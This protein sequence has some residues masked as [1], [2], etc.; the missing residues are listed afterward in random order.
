M[1]ASYSANGKCKQLTNSTDFYTFDDGTTL[2]WNTARWS[3]SE[4]EEGNLY[5]ES[6]R[7]SVLFNKYT[8]S[9][10]QDNAL[11]DGDM[12][13]LMEALFHAND[14]DIEFDPAHFEA[15]RVGHFPAGYY[16]FRDSGED[17]DYEHVFILLHFRNHSAALFS[18]IPLDGEHL[19][20]MDAVMKL[21][22][23]FTD[24]S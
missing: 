5:L 21:I 2:S 23:G 6:E 12:S 10:Y 20:E 7:T 13:G 1:G 22:G 14:A 17:A 11:V 24:V 16:S 18:I 4:D 8:D 15:I 19:I 3:F 9:I